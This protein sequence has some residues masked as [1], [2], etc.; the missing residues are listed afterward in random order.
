MTKRYNLHVRACAKSLGV[1]SRGPQTLGLLFASLFSTAQARADEPV[2]TELKW[3]TALKHQQLDDDRFVGQRFVFSCPEHDKR[4]RAP[5][6]RGTHVYASD[7]PICAAAV[8]AGVIGPRGGRVTVQLNPGIDRYVGSEKNG[9]RSNAAP[10]TRRSLVFVGDDFARG[11]TPVQRE[12][13]PTVTWTTKFTATGLANRKLIGQRFVFRCP[14]APASLPGRVV[15][16][17]DRYAF[18]SLICLSAVHAGR[19]TSDGGF[20]SVRMIEAE[21]PLEGSIRHG[22]ESKPGPA[23][24]RQ[25][26]FET[27]S[28][29][30]A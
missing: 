18:P 21:H 28:P 19:L 3:D 26:V 17:T 30:D 27:L 5:E 7:S 23:G 9:V 13:L 6:L 24:D 25:I 11:L 4:H 2:P 15:Y 12:L 14:K 8:H 1:R 16:G 22:I 10:A 20:V 29:D